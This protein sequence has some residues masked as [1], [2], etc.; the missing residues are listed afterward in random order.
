MEWIKVEDR[1]PEATIGK[2]R[3]KALFVTDDGNIYLGQVYL[4]VEGGTSRY[5]WYIRYQ[6]GHPPP[7]KERVTHWMPLPSPPG[8][9]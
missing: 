8:K 9:E 5:S 4:E 1:S 2:V 3:D 6:D 7:S